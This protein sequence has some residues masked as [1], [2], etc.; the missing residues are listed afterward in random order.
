MRKIIR[1]GVKDGQEI[2]IN[3]AKRGADCGCA[4]LGCGQPLIARQGEERI[5]HFAHVLKT[6]CD[7][8]ETE[9]HYNS[10]EILARHISIL[11]EENTWFQYDTCLKEYKIGNMRVDALLINSST[12]EKLVVEIVNR[13]ELSDEKI[14]LLNALGYRVLEINLSEYVDDLPEEELTQI[15]IFETDDKTVFNPDNYYEAIDNYTAGS[16]ESTSGRA[17]AGL[18]AVF[19]VFIFFIGFIGF[20]KS[21]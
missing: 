1:V 2:F 20:R 15:V 6:D 18:L 14:E 13:H 4:C 19:L 3:N 5:W 11:I 9:N 17:M 16:N 12:N 8:G 7:Y 21:R 10:K